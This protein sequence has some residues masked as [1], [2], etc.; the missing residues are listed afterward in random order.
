MLH[1]VGLVRDFVFF[2][3]GKSKIQI[4]FPSIDEMN[5]VSIIWLHKSDTVN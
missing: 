4:L 2:K 3:E 5:L 1:D